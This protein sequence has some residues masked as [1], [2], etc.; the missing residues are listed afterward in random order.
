MV[1]SAVAGFA[2]WRSSLVAAPAIRGLRAQAEEIRRA[3]VARMAGSLESLS[4]DERERVEILT[5]AIVNKI[6]HEPTVRAREAVQ[7]AEGL[8][9]IESLRHLFGLD[10]P[11][12]NGDGSANTPPVAPAAHDVTH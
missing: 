4:D 6:L 11:S 7:N 10:E 1:G 12:G 9:H 8:R 5:K 3:E 2:E